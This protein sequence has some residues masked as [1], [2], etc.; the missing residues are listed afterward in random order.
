MLELELG[1]GSLSRLWAVLLGQVDLK[2]DLILDL[3]HLVSLATFSFVVVVDCLEYF[4]FLQAVVLFDD[5]LLKVP[6]CW[7]RQKVVWTRRKSDSE[8]KLEL[9]WYAD[10]RFV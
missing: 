9:R 2:I 4:F 6:T 5:F 10:Q 3:G 8:G 1:W 7:V